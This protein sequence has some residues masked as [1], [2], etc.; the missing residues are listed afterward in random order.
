[1][2]YIFT[3]RKD[4]SLD[5]FKESACKKGVDLKVYYYND[6]YLDN[7]RLYNKSSGLIH[8]TDQDGIILRDPYLY[9][10]QADY[11]Y[12]FSF[13]LSKYYDLILLDKQYYKS[14]PNYEDKLLQMSLL[15]S[16]KVPY[17]KTYYCPTLESL[18]RL[19]ISFPFILKKRMSSRGI[20]VHLIQNRKTLNEISKKQDFSQYLVQKFISVTKDYRILVFR[21][22]ICGAVRRS[23][24]IKDN[25]KVGVKIIGAGKV[26]KKIERDVIEITKNLKFDLA[27]I[28]VIIDKK[29]NYFFLE[30]NLSPQFT[31]FTKVTGLNPSD[32]IVEYFEK[33]KNT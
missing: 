24:C 3:L 9:V 1:M 26:N 28:D 6:L 23:H 27:G 16:L 22:E 30:I 15:K 33:N 25:S 2:L 12:L 29:G 13:I 31:K 4:F 10:K 5:L 32:L 8:L 7:F 20:D 21:G 11:S 18:K 19:K 17:P 14:F